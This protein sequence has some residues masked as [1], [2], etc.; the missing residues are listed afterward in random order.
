MGIIYPGFINQ[1]LG[2]DVCMEWKECMN[3]WVDGTL[4]EWIERVD[5]LNK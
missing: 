5:G 4:T 1:K 2:F 3:E